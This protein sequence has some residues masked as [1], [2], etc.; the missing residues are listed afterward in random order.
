MFRYMPIVIE[1]I[2]ING[3]NENDIYV[4]ATPNDVTSGYLNEKL[5]TL[6]QSIVIDSTEATKLNLTVGIIDCGNW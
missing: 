1:Q 4:K 5:G 6:N 3:N 2:I